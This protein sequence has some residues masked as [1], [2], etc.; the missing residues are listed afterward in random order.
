MSFR[1]GIIGTMLSG[2]ALLLGHA[3]GASTPRLIWNASASVPIGLY[4]IVAT[5]HLHLGD[6]VM[7]MP[8][9]RLARF[10]A[11]RGYL[12]DGVLLLKHVAALAGATV[13]RK[14]REIT[15]NGVALGW[16]QERDG[17]G[18]KL[19]V[20]RGCHHL[21]SGDVFLMNRGIPDSFDGRYFGPL[22][23]A[24]IV[25]QALP[26]W[27][28]HGSRYAINGISD[29]GRRGRHGARASQTFTSTSARKE[30]SDAPDRHLQPH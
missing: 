25:G 18:R 9:A 20:W 6:L 23:T 16:A 22:S 29:P 17:S 13:C 30:S 1:F 14:D 15:V 21:L 7:V 10:M 27:T 8:P 3:A 28:V 12:P 5:G 11:D 24:T 2:V 26:V 19:P 4:R